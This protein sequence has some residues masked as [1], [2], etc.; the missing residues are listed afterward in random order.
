[1]SKIITDS[2]ILV[3]NSTLTTVGNLIVIANS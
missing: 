3:M 1:M 2:E